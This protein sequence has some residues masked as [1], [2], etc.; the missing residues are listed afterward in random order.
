MRL[1][2]GALPGGGITS[3]APV[4]TQHWDLIEADLHRYYHLDLLDLFRPGRLSW[5]KLDVL[6]KHLPTD[7]AAARA[8]AGTERDPWGTSEHLLATAVDLLAVQAWMFAKANS[9]R[10]NVRA[11]KPLPRPNDERQAKRDI[12]TIRPSQL[13]HWLTTGEIPTT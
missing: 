2:P 6:L 7:S 4:L 1:A 10:F 3:L 9:K 13:R 11:P 12:P 5:R 8:I